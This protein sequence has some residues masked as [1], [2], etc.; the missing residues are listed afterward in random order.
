MLETIRNIYCIGR[1]YKAHA[2][3]LGNDVPEQ[4]MVFL[5]PTHSLV[6]MDGRTIRLPGNRGSVHYEGELVVRIGQAYTP[7]MKAEE[8][9]EAIAFGLD[10]TLRDLQGKLKQ[11]G[12]PWLPAK[13]F[14]DSAPLG[15]FLPF[16]GFEE[17][18]KREYVLLRN[19]QIAQR[20]RIDRM[21]FSIGAI[22]DYCAEHYGLGA[23]D[24]IF[25][26]TPEG[27]GPVA[28]GDRFTFLW[29][30]EPV[31]ECTIELVG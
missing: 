17:L 13:G 21:I 18:A 25:T 23:G 11:K 29:G 7:G 4:P 31:G 16:P 8:A 1:N 14:K 19:G 28:S 3:E 27:V 24:L 2:E 12:H 10:M 26:G 22:M 9:I 6:P 15:P 30:D 20:G 5:K